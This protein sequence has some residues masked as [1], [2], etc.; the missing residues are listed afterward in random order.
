MTF[1]SLLLFVPPWSKSVLYKNH[2][3]SNMHFTGNLL[4]LCLLWGSGHNLIGHLMPQLDHFRSERYIHTAS[5]SSYHLQFSTICIWILHPG[6]EAPI[7]WRKHATVLS[8]GANCAYSVALWGLLEKIPGEASTSLQIPVGFFSQ[9][10]GFRFKII[11]I[12]LIWNQNI[13][14]LIK[15]L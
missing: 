10:S 1:I 3:N 12:V 13:V 11:K 7:K 14:L 5:V 2:N 6:T 8:S 9:V 4:S 15:F